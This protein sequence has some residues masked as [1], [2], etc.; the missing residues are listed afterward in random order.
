MTKRL[1]SNKFA[2]QQ[3]LSFK[4]GNLEEYYTIQFDKTQ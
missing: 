4:P 2:M 3:N 1:R